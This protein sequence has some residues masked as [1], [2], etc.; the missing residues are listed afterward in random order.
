MTSWAA[1]S[2][3]ASPA[4]CLQGNRRFFAAAIRRRVFAVGNEA[5]SPLTHASEL[6]V[7]RIALNDDGSPA[8]VLVAELDL[9]WLRQDLAAKLPPDALLTV[10]DRNG[11]EVLQAAGAKKA[12]RLGGADPDGWIISPAPV[13]GNQSGLEVIVARPRQS[14]FAALDRTTRNGLVLIALALLLACL[15]T[16]W[17]GRRFIQAPIQVLLDATDRL[18]GGD[19]TACIEP[20]AD[21]SEL[22]RLGHGLNALAQDLEQRAHAQVKAESQLRQF[23]TTLEERVAERTRALE[24]T[25]QRLAAEA[26]QRQCT[27][28]ELAQVQKLDAIGK[29]T[30][31]IA[32]DFNNLLA[33]AN[34]G[35]MLDHHRLR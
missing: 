22:A 9:S 26:E 4:D 34:N 24:E 32:H 15:A 13:D 7:A 5:V 12:A 25:T 21:T 28:A 30:G 1:P 31:G 2:V 20:A 3:P 18:R 27:Q 14:A 19:Y 35:Y 16:V 17:I 10:T 8:D 11:R 29:L 33:A 6:P 23:A